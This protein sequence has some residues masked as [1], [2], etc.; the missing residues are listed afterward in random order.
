MADTKK[1]VSGI[2][3]LGFGALIKW[4]D[5]VLN[6]LGLGGVPDDMM[7]WQGWIL[8][9]GGVFLLAG[10]LFLLV[11]GVLP[12]QNSR[13]IA[14]PSRDEIEADDAVTTLDPN[15]RSAYLSRPTL[16]IYEAACLFAG[17]T[18]QRPV[19]A[20]AAL[21]YAEEFQ[22]AIRR[23]K[24]KAI[25]PRPVTMAMMT[26]MDIQREMES[27]EYIVNTL[28]EETVISTASV[29]E[30][31]ERKQPEPFTPLIEVAASALARIRD[32]DTHI[33]INYAAYSV[34]NELRRLANLITKWHD[35]HGRIPHTQAI[36]K[37]R[38]GSYSTDITDSGDLVAVEAP[39]SD[40]IAFVDLTIPTAD[41]E[42]VISSTIRRLRDAFGLD[43]T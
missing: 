20:G 16:K 35:V 10:G 9:Y 28:S 29:I 19:P 14:S 15:C 41:V 6:I 2:G 32:T 27:H 17:V 8:H 24:I 5:R 43:E 11:W 21:S 18:P 38:A 34:T 30:Y 23:K 25:D 36:H 39:N 1:I 42:Q 40:K 7:T 33:I 22:D 3:T 4:G 31:M 26:T 12:L 37:I 13:K